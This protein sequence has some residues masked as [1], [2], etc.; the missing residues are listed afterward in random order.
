MATMNNP[1]KNILDLSPNIIM[2]V[3]ENNIGE[4]YIYDNDRGYVLNGITASDLI[5]Y[6]AY[7]DDIHLSEEII[8]ICMDVIINQ[9]TH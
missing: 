8:D 5:D 3:D 9:G 7:N 1:N 6:F 2:H 4:M